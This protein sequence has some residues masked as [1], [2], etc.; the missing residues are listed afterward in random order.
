MWDHDFPAG[1]APA[2]D[3]QAL[4]TRHF[5]PVEDALCFRFLQYYDTYPSLLSMLCE[6]TGPCYPN[7]LPVAGGGGTN[8]H[9]M[10]YR[11]VW[12]SLHPESSSEGI[13]HL[14]F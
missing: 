6:L 3:E 7:L 10:S 12:F 4:P 1:I 8:P 13:R 2:E 9:A 11:T 14:W 5:A